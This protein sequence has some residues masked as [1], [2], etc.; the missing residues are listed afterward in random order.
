MYPARFIFN[1][2][3]RCLPLTRAEH[4]FL[5]L[6]Q[7]CYHDAAPGDIPDPTHDRYH[8]YVCIYGPQRSE[9]LRTD[10]STS[11]FL[12]DLQL[13]QW[14]ESDAAYKGRFVELIVQSG[15]RVH[16]V[17]LVIKSDRQ[18][19]L[20]GP[21]RSRQYP[22]VPCQ[23][24]HERVDGSGSTICVFPDLF[25]EGVAPDGSAIRVQAEM[26]RKAYFSVLLRA[27]LF[28]YVHEFFRSTIPAFQKEMFL[29]TVIIDDLISGDALVPHGIQ[30]PKYAVLDAIC[31][32]MYPGPDLLIPTNCDRT[33]PMTNGEFLADN[34]AGMC[35]V[36]LSTRNHPWLESITIM[37]KAKQIRMITLDDFGRITSF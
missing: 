30:R 3:K 22:T 16:V 1:K 20:F 26:K 23:Y 37:R 28:S 18:E 25:F 21:L 24:Y 29:G 4:R 11:A 9:L 32:N 33:K 36:A 5:W 15:D 34:L 14:K 2:I 17:V 12:P 27:E 6:C 13:K 10:P 31:R 7:Y 19:A 35:K 8:C